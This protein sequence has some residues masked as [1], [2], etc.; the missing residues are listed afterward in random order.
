MK[1]FLITISLLVGVAQAGDRTTAYNI[2][3][4]PMTFESE[5]NNCLSKIRNYSYFD[6][7]ALGICAAVTFDSNKISCLNVIGDK[8][9]EEYEMDKCVN[10]TFE[11]KKLDC[12]HKLGTIYNPNRPSCVPTEE[13]IAQLSYSLK[14]LRSG[15]QGST[16]QRLSNLL[17]KFMDCN[18]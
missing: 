18:R 7:R 17:A 11:S 8:A 13:V 12:L 6:N 2:I 16:D 5:R 9:Y 10:E 1:S 4:K 14:D 3:C 15:N